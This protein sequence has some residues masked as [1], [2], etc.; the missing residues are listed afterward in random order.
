M[1]PAK[2]QPL[3][4]TLVRHGTTAWNEGGRW[5]GLTDVPLGPQGETQAL[6][7]REQLRSEHFDQVF[8]SDLQ[9]AA[10]TAE[11]ALPGAPLILDPRLREYSFGA[12]E[13]FTVPEMQAHAGFTPWQADPWG[14]PVPQGESLG[15][16]ARRMRAWADELPAGRIIAFSH[17]I[18][19]RTLLVDLFGLPLEPQPNYPIP[20]RER[21][22]NGQLVT[23]RREGGVWTREEG[24]RT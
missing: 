3:T 2:A 9:R 17:S 22:G 18:A 8:S 12:F 14:Q 24:S 13:G 19:I 10:R 7:L 15:D 21:L 5:Q 1:T 4:L 16:V 23:L 6:N 11:L 20:Y